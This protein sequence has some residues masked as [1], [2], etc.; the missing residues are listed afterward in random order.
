M[1][2]A[3]QK[4]C[5]ISKLSQTVTSKV[6]SWTRADL[7]LASSRTWWVSLP[8]LRAQSHHTSFSV[9]SP[10]YPHA[11]SAVE[12]RFTSSNL[13][14]Y[15]YSA[16]LQHR[17]GNIFINNRDSYLVIIVS[18]PFSMSS[19]LLYCNYHENRCIISHFTSC[20]CNYILTYLWVW[21]TPILLVYYV[22]HNFGMV[23]LLR[24]I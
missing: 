13:V 12:D 14:C 20:H 16:L 5:L 11:T 15:T 3:C 2:H 6:K 4:C 7:V 17:I 10:T 21:H 9:C 18:T 22:V 1:T 24:L 23:N 8:W 19:L